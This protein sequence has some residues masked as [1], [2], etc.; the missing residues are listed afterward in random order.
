MFI[1]IQCFKACTSIG[2]RLDREFEI[3][4]RWWPQIGPSR[5]SDISTMP[6]PSL[7]NPT[8][9]PTLASPMRALDLSPSDSPLSPIESSVVRLGGHGLFARWPTKA[10]GR[11]RWGCSTLPGF[12]I[13]ASKRGS[14]P[15]IRQRLRE[16]RIRSSPCRIPRDL[17]PDSHASVIRYGRKEGR[18]FPFHALCNQM[19]NMVRD[20][21][22]MTSAEGEG[23][24]HF[25]RILIEVGCMCM[26]TN[27]RG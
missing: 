5:S 25:I 16:T 26:L 20:H 21:S 12:L 24:V 27:E 8:A 10:G 11:R 1:S 7:T 22:H 17:V 18:P 3:C 19:S 2:G 23:G 4:Y 13:T 14:L 9:T 15:R 6:R